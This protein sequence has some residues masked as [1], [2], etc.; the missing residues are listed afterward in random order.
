MIKTETADYIYHLNQHEDG[1]RYI[2]SLF[3]TQVG[4]INSM[5]EGRKISP[6]KANKRIKKLYK[7]YIKTFKHLWEINDEYKKSDR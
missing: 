5:M 4:Y 2:N 1:L 3:S 7:N 6:K